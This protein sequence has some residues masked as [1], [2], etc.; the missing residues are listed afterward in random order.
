MS[1][2][3]LLLLAATPSGCADMSEIAPYMELSWPPA[4]HALI[5]GESEV[6]LSV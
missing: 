3:L 4:G 2:L 1:F 5:E 6:S